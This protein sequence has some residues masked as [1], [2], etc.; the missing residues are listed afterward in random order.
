MRRSGRALASIAS[1]FAMIAGCERSLFFPYRCEDPR[2]PIPS[3][4]LGYDDGFPERQACAYK[5]GDLT[6]KTVGQNAPY[7]SPISYVIVVLHENRSF[8][9]Y[10]QTYQRPG[11]LGDGETI[12]VAP[13][14]ITLPDPSQN[15]PGMVSPRPA[16][17]DAGS[18]AAAYCARDNPHEWSD[19]HLQY[20]N[21]LLDGFVASANVGFPV[22]GGTRAMRYFERSDLPFYHWLAD[23]FAISDHYFAPALA[24]S[25][26]N[27]MFYFHATSC[28]FTDSWQQEPAVA[29]CGLFADSI[30]GRLSKANVP[31]GAYSTNP[32]VFTEAGASVVLGGYDKLVGTLDDF[33]SDIRNKTLPAVTFFEPTYDGR[34]GTQNDEH[35]PTNLQ[36]GQLMSYQVVTAVMSE[37][38]IWNRAVIFLTWDENGGFYDHFPPPRACPPDDAQHDHLDWQFDRYGFRVPLIAVSPFARKG[39]IS[40]Y[41]ADHTSILRFI[42]HWQHL[43]AITARD[44]NAWPLLDLFDFSTTPQNTPSPDPSLS[45]SPQPCPP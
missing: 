32:R 12:E 20:D 4:H 33:R 26:A 44:A 39:H 40:H 24:P 30:F 41:V 10:F 45:P 3:P 36:L 18:A 34:F 23:N 17:S 5:P 37:P 21:G 22:G 19:V 25:D 11:G 42:E 2:E 15:P 9:S 35:P 8:D 6:G 27:I 13:T 1:L 29:K 38:E 7:P 16:V 31:Y 14:H 28:G 43:G